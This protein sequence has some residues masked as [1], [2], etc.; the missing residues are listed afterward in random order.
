MYSSLISR[1]VASVRKSISSGRRIVA[2]SWVTAPASEYTYGSSWY[3]VWSNFNIAAYAVLL[4]PPNCQISR[5]GAWPW[6]RM[7]GRNV[8]NSNQRAFSSYHSA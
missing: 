6:T 1:A 5:R 2:A 8:A 4:L 7:M 3:R